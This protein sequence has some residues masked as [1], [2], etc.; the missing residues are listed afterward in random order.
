MP[1]NKAYPYA[2]TKVKDVNLNAVADVRV[3]PPYPKY[4]VRT[5]SVTN[6]STSLA[7]SSATIGLYTA[8]AAGGTAI[9][10]AAVATAL[11]AATKL[12][13]RTLASTDVQTA[14]P[15]Y[16]NV[17]VAHGSAATCDCYIEFQEIQ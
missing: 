14:N 9:S 12:A 13:D 6:A 2:T 4:A 11:T 15:L 17:G 1:K 3:L 7:A 8:A 5:F 16:V 10:A